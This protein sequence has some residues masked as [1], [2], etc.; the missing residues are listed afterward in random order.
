P[1]RNLR[2]L[3]SSG[4]ALAPEERVEIREKLCPNFYEYYASTEGGGISVLSPVDQE[5]Y[6]D[7][8]GRPA[9]GV[10]VSIVNDQHEPAAPGTVGRVRYRSNGTAEGFFGDPEA[11]AEVFRDGWFYP[12]DLG[13]MNDEGYLFLKGRAKDV[14]IRGGVNIY[15]QE[16]DA[17]LTTH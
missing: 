16:I 4:S 15:P 3:I 13:M 14:I 17:C 12:G 6:T 10:E 9:F 11:S 1:M 8:V 5:R 2:T 7:S